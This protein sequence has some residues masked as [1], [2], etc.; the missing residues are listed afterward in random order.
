MPDLM[1]R[2]IPGQTYT[3]FAAHAARRGQSVEDAVLEFL[4]ATAI[5]ETL[6]QRLERA[7]QAAENVEA[8][9]AKEAATA[10][11]PRRRYRSVH[12]T[13]RQR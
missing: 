13:P 12:P 3:A 8:A 1:I 9:L 10:P 4:R 6:M 11:R 5:E 2:A 7:S